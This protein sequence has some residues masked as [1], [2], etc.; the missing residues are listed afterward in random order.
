MAT[1]K[2][3][4]IKYEEPYKDTLDLVNALL[5]EKGLSGQMKTRILSDNKSKKVI[6]HT[7]SNELL[8][9]ETKYDLYIFINEVIF[10]QLEDWQQLLI[11]EEKLAEF[12]WNDEEEKL[13]IQKKEINTF[14]LVLQQYS[15][16][17]YENVRESIKTLYA[18]EK[19]NAEV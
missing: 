15:F 8:K 2:K 12:Y 19:E 9:Y 7:K 3:K 6:S 11:V 14:S 4:T 13:V 1:S 5:S 17:S 16:E 18:A 10:D